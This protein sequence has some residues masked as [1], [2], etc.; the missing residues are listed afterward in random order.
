MLSRVR[1]LEELSVGILDG[2]TCGDDWTD[3]WLADRAGGQLKSGLCAMHVGLDKDDAPIGFFTLS[4]CQ[5]MPT[6]ALQKKHHGSNRTP[7]GA[8]CIGEL[9]IRAD[10]RDRGL[11]YRTQLLNHA[12]FL[13]CDIAHVAGVS[14]IAVSPHSDDE[15]LLRWY[16]HNGF[17]ASPTGSRYY[18][19][20]RKAKERI[21]AL[22]EDYFHFG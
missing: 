17:V 6:D 2:F 13:A 18:M 5:I 11:G 10:L 20:I 21:G 3:N 14:L 4:T 22:G 1:R 8:L 16:R 19:P 15:H 12:I 7:F 9:A